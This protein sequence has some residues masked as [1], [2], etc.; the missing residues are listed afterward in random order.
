MF[1]NYTKLKYL[2]IK[3]INT[4]K[5]FKNSFN[6]EELFYVCQSMRII[7]NSYTYN[8]CDY[9]IETNE[10]DYA[11]PT[12]IPDSTIVPTTTPFEIFTSLPTTIP[13]TTPTT[14]PI[15]VAIS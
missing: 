14:I 13:T 8:C 12:A 4:N 1:L 15:T 5:I 6:N 10:C 3:N 7:I 9:N 11:P 2:D